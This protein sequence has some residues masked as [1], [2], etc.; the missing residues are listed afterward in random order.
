MTWDRDVEVSRDDGVRDRCG[1]TGEG[2]GRDTET[3]R[4]VV[5]IVLGLS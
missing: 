2:W 3:F 5:C 1:P 4:E